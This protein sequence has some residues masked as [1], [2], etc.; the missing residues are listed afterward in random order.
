MD[1]QQQQGKLCHPQEIKDK[2]TAGRLRGVIISFHSVLQQM[3]LNWRKSS[4]VN[5][6]AEGGKAY[7]TYI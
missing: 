7:K 3:S 1:R 4:T 5:Q 6:D 2:S